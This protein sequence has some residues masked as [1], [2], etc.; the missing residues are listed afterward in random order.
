MALDTTHKILDTTHKLRIGFEIENI[1][2]DKT[3]GKH[4]SDH[5]DVVEIFRY[6]FKNDPCP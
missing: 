1:E 2:H 6:N 5:L 4:D 3:M